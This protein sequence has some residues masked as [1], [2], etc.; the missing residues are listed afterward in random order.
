[1]VIQHLPEEQT[2]QIKIDLSVNRK[3][4]IKGDRYVD[5]NGKNQQKV[6]TFK[7]PNLSKI[8]SVL[9]K[10]GANISQIT[11]EGRF[12]VINYIA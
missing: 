7:Y 5:C 3:Y 4:T 6:S 8:I 10:T 11:V 2:G 12:T 1:M 9:E